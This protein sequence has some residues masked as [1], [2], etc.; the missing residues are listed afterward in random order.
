MGDSDVSIPGDYSGRWAAVRSD[1]PA[2][3][4]RPQLA[5]GNVLR[6][7]G[8]HR[9][10]MR[11]RDRCPPCV[12][13]PRRFRSTWVTRPHAGNV[14]RPRPPARAK[15][16]NVKFHSPPSRSTFFTDERDRTAARTAFCTG[17][18]DHPEPRTAFCTGAQ[19]HP[20]PRAAFCTGVRFFPEGWAAF[21]TGGW[22]RKWVVQ[23]SVPASEIRRR[24]GQR[25]VPADSADRRP[26]R[27][28]APAA[29]FSRAAVRRF[30]TRV[31][32][33]RRLV[34]TCELAW[35]LLGK[36]V[37]I[38]YTGSGRPKSG[39]GRCDLVFSGRNLA[40]QISELVGGENGLAVGRSRW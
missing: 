13:W 25:S 12:G 4:D 20:E 16:R 32:I 9:R 28:A 3:G 35:E 26:V 15:I 23:R 14:S 40:F 37:P 22:C 33:Q 18:Q 7:L 11:G 17:A 24:V 34:R 21:C 1:K 5:A 6:I 39:V 31:G 38:S 27:N 30:E 29:G 8:T 19:D 2:S 36:A 10:E